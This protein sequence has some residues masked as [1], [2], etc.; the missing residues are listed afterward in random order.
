[1]AKLL[2][3]ASNAVDEGTCQSE[4]RADVTLSSNMLESLLSVY[5]IDV[6]LRAREPRVYSIYF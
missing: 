5:T 6:K 3:N 1:M 2:W 4:H